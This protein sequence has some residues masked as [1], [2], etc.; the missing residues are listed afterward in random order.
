MSFTSKL[1]V[2]PLAAVFAVPAFAAD[3]MIKDAY[4][5]SAFDG[6]KT[7]AAFMQ[8][9]NPLDEDDR[10]IA[11]KSG[12]AK[13]IQLHTHKD[14][15]EGVMKMMHVAEGFA[16]PAGGTRALS[17]GGDH[18]MLMG[19]TQKLIDGDA[20][21][22]TLVFDKAGEIVVQ[23]PVDRER[24]DHGA[25]KHEDMDHSDGSADK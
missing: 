9:M 10:L 8:I 20:I 23:V 22:L 7:G 2:I 19:L 15:G 4:A 13:K 25:M 17:R 21:E 1:L 18:V 14:M 3:I 12:V 16:I 5:R 11:V 6:A 24:Q